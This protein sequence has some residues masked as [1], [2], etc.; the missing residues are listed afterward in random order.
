MV[1]NKLILAISIM[2]IS[3]SGTKEILDADPQIDK[4]ELVDEFERD[5]ELGNYDPLKE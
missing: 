1:N 5:I 2:F 3:C 4:K